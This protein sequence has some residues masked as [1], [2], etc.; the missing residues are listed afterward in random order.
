MTSDGIDSP[1]STLNL[2]MPS[3]P[4][5]SLKA[6]LEERRARTASAGQLE[7]ETTAPEAV[8][9]LD[10][11]NNRPAGSASESASDLKLNPAAASPQQENEA[12]SALSEARMFGSATDVDPATLKAML[13]ETPADVR[14]DKIRLKG[15]GF[16]D[17]TFDAN[18]QIRDAIATVGMLLSGHA[19][20]ELRAAETESELLDAL[21]LYRDMNHLSLAGGITC[22]HVVAHVQSHTV[23]LYFRGGE[24]EAPIAV[25]AATFSMRQQSMMLRLLATHPRMTRKGF[26]RVTVHFLKELCRALQKTEIIVYTYPSSASFYKAL[27]FSHTH[28][29]IANGE[30]VRPPIA[31]ADAD[32]RAREAARDARRVFSAKENEMI[33]YVQPTME[34]VLQQGYKS[35][36]AV[37]AHPYACTRRHH[38]SVSASTGEERSSSSSSSMEKAPPPAEAPAAPEPSRHRR[39]RQPAPAPAPTPAPAPA[40]EQRSSR[41]RRTG[42]PEARGARSDPSTTPVEVEGSGGRS[43]SASADSAALAPLTATSSSASRAAWAAAVSPLLP[44]SQPLQPSQ[45]PASEELSKSEEANSPR[46]RTKT[47][48]SE[49]QVEK[50]VDVCR[51]STDEAQY[52][53]KWKGWPPKFNTW[54]PLSHLQNLT[55]EIAAFEMLRAQQSND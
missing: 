43:A 55:S 34:Q 23:L 51:T 33:Y 29:H 27:H 40:P 54:E 15:Q 44:S 5:P 26:G 32:D 45:P 4:A 2:I 21:K 24:G 50:I 20:L 52:L 19:E 30:A 49:Y 7:C 10:L 12:P 28:P 48:K 35:G 39:S 42:R 6:G 13:T 16:H 8:H 18:I 11:G 36:T 22:E 3:E 9:A 31:A 25:T 38:A 47:S 1:S 46:K 53:I 17:E 41:G 14:F 37:M